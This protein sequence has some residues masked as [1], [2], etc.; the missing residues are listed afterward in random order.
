[1]KLFL[2]LEVQ[3]IY[4]SK[5]FTDKKSGEVTKG[6]W[7]IQTFDKIESEDGKQLKMYDISLPDDKVD[8]YKQ[9]LGK[10]IKLPVST[11]VSNGRVGF[12][13]I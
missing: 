8:E 3:N 1:M 6:K 9:S 12:Y 2:E 10:T 7:K 13:S 4:K 11:Y 5:D